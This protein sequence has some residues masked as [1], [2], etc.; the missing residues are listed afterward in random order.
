MLS[1]L[2]TDRTTQ[3]L[4]LTS[5]H[6]SQ[7]SLDWLIHF[8]EVNPILRTVYL[9]NNKISAFQVKNRKADIARLGLELIV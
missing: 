5:N 1:Y 6:L 2:S 8:A 9:S 7:K 3:V 4:N